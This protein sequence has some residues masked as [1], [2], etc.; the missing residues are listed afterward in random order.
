MKILIHAGFAHSGTTSLQKNFFSSRPDIFYGG[1]P[2]NKLGEIFSFIKHSDQLYDYTYVNSLCDQYIW[3]E[4]R[5][6]QRLVL[7]DECFVEQ[8]EVYYTPR[9]I[10]QK[11]IALRLKEL[12][13]PR[14]PLFMS[15]NSSIKIL[16]TIRNQYDYITS[17]YFNLKKNYAHL[18]KRPIEDFDAWFEGNHT[19]VNNLFLRNTDYSLAIKDFIDVFGRE[20]VFVLP[21]ESIIHHGIKHYLEYICMLLEISLSDDD[22]IRYSQ[23]HNKRMTAIEEI[24]LTRWSEMKFR[25][26]FDT[27]LNNVIS[28]VPIIN[29]ESMDQPVNLVLSENQKT[30]LKEKVTNANLF[31]ESEFKIPLKYYGYP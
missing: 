18:A 22:V 1:I 26:T 14:P 11:V 5:P 10:M 17:T 9:M 25:D 2:Y 15:S 12:F 30:S 21:L 3:G 24:A 6:D 27:V 4:I 8:P 7:S 13:R 28:N 19:Q 29:K 31:I 23:I 16:F 20:N